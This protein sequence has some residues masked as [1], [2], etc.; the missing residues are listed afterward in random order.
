MAEER[1]QLDRAN[2]GNNLAF[3]QAQIDDAM[4]RKR[5][6]ERREKRY[7]KPHFGP[8]ESEEVVALERQRQHNQRRYVHNQLQ[9]QI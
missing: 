3:I 5:E 7:Y 4:A 8:E 6:F 1:S 2:K 9:N